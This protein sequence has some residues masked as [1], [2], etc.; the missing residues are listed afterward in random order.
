LLFIC[1]GL[2]TDSLIT[3]PPFTQNPA[4]E[5]AAGGLRAGSAVPLQSGGVEEE[6]VAACVRSAVAKVDAH[7]LPAGVGDLVVIHVHGPMMC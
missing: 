6:A 4:V 5:L 1:R 3:V 7:R 2:H